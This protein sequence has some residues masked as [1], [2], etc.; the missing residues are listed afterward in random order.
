MT[1]DMPYKSKYLVDPPYKSKYL[2]DHGRPP[3]AVCAFCSEGYFNLPSWLDLAAPLFCDGVC[4]QEYI[5]L[6]GEIEEF[7]ADA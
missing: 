6:E 1:D 5:A 7:K 3:Q 4:E 2:A